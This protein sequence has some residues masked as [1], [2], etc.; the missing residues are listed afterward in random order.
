V[1]DD[2]V[3]R[4]G[5]C[6]PGLHWRGVSLATLLE[7]AG[8]DESAA[9]IEVASGSFATSLPREEALRELLATH[10][11]DAVLQPE[12]GGPVRLVVPGAD[13]YTS[14]KWVDRIEVLARPS[15]D[16]AREIALA[17][18]DRAGPATGDASASSAQ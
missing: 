3:C 18:L 17:R 12:H 9:W 16:R 6:V 2:F 14:I 4:E 5:W 8:A 10:L 11:G 15:R 1:T 7:A 13:C